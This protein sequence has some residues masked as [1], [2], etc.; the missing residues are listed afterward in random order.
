VVSR[1]NPPRLSSLERAQNGLRAVAAR[2]ERAAVK[3][4]ISNKNLSIFDVLFDARPAIQRMKVIELLEATPGVGKKRAVQIMDKAKISPSRRIAG[5]G[6]HQIEALREELILNKQKPTPGLLIVMS[7]PGG[8]GK[9][10]ISAALRNHPSFWLSIS[11]TTRAPRDGEIHGEDY[12]FMDDDEF[13]RMVKEES[14]LEWAEFAGNRYGTPASEVLKQLEYGKN[15]LLEIEIAGAR[16]IRKVNPEALFIFIAPPSWEELE[17]R[18]IGR[19][20]DSPERRLARLALA[21]EEM[22]AASEFDEILVNTEVKKVA[23]AL[24][25]LAATKKERQK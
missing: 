20:T 12:F 11:A 9:S 21:K 3:A 5:L 16:Q 1:E 13:D 18:L 4:E 19:G 6:K 2:R 22:A 10:T 7:G 23:E 25:S 17:A 8:V 24:V 15:V 14:F